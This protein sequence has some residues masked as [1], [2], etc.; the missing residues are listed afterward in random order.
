MTEYSLN[1]LAYRFGQ[2][3]ETAA[4][5]QQPEHFKVQELIRV[6]PDGTGEHL[7]LNIRKRGMNTQF[8]MKQVAR[9]AGVS[10]RNVS[11]A[12]LKDRHAVTEQWLSVQ[13]PG[14][15][16]P[17]IRELENDD[18]QVIAAHRHSQKLRSAVLLANRFELLLTNVSDPQAV[19]ERWQQVS[20]G[21]PNY[22]GEQRFGHSFGNIDKAK[23]V[24]AGKR[25]KRHLQS[26]FLSAAR[27][28]L[29][30][31]MISQRLEQGQFETLIAGDMLMLAGSRSHFQNQGEADLPERL[32]S[33]DVQLSAPL[34]G[35]GYEKLEGE[36]LALAQSVANSEPELAEGLVKQRVKMALR[37]ILLKPEH[38][39]ID[40]VGKDV[41]IS[42]VLPSGSF[43]TSV[44][45]ELVSYQ[46]A[47]GS[48]HADLGE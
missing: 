13:L 12:G 24:F 38:G 18:I 8:L 27:S 6:E 33:G 11:H 47:S 37:P 48:V 31:C 19:V 25:V 40:L 17:D 9:W 29:F 16:D 23:Q 32:A 44:L 28:W 36:Y 7:W 35:E 30:N 4:I 41:K 34:W 26:L 5:R 10:E 42:F 20:R 39:R 46:D 1:K 2:P 22:F 21:V 3:T 43:A 45:R 15:P 14:K